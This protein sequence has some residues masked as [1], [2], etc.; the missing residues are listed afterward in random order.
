MPSAAKPR[1]KPELISLDFEAIGTIWNITLVADPGAAPSLAK[2]IADRISEFDRTYS[3]FRS[4]SWVT[5]IGSQPGKHNAPADFAPMFKLY[6]QM[7]AVTNGAVT[8]L[9]GDAMER[10]GYD[11]MYSLTPTKLRTIPA[12]DDVM[13]FSNNTLHVKYKCVIDFGAAGKGYLVDLIAELLENNGVG[14]YL[15]DAGGDMRVA[16]PAP[17]KSTS[18]ALEDPNDPKK[19]IGVVELGRNLQRSSL[20]GS[21]GNRRVWA[22]FHHIIDPHTLRPTE[23]VRATWAVASSALVADGMATC[24]FFTELKILADRFD[25]DYVRIMADN[26]VQVSPGFPGQVF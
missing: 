24:L 7:Y 17:S 10:A 13:H 5:K 21:A 3:R 23:K 8:P 11:S 1:S 4:D 14:Q 16:S 12:L 22:D 9:I 15:I 2:K 20:C 19:A 18:V 6:Q 26:S 25:F